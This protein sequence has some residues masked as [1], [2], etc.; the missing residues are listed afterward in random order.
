MENQTEITDKGERKAH[1][2]QLPEG[3]LTRLEAK[4][5][6]KTGDPAQCGPRDLE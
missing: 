5:F 4:S 1:L 6:F 3:K 2:F